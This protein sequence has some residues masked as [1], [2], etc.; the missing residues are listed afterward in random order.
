MKLDCSHTRISEL[1]E[2]PEELRKLN[3]SYTR[4]RS[5]PNL[6]A[7][8]HYLDCSYTRLLKLP[9]MP[10]VISYLD[11]SS[12]LVNTLPELEILP[13]RFGS[14]SCY[15]TRLDPALMRYIDQGDLDSVNYYTFAQRHK[16][17]LKKDV[18]P[19]LNLWIALGCD[20]N[21]EYMETDHGVLPA[22][23][24][25]IIAGFLC[26]ATNKHPLAA[27]VTEFRSHVLEPIVRPE[28]IL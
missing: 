24:M 1:P 17:A 27:I 5:L 2:L 26:A 25:R 3:C 19:V 6:P 9:K 10:Q 21:F 8:L 20:K 23:I 11:C 28:M 14:L 18:R 4:I 22:E 13:F 16:E 12:T 15:N 7:N